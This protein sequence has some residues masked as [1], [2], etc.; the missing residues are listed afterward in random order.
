MTTTANR[1]PKAEFQAAQVKAR[2]RMVGLHGQATVGGKD[3]TFVNR[4]WQRGVI[5]AKGESSLTVKSKDGV[6]WT[7]NL[8]QATRIHKLG[9]RADLS[10][11]VAGDAGDKIFVIGVT[12]QG[13]RLLRP[14]PRARC[15]SPPGDP[16][17][18]ASYPE[19]GIT[20]PPP[21]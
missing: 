5:T 13:R 19:P 1:P 11:L 8:D 21:R 10:T 2:A 6:T 18:A 3:S 17:G 20:R 7:W 4:V 9:A 12:G 16:A 14:P 15:T